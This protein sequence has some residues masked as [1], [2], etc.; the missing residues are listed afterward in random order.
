MATTKE[1]AFLA[2]LDFKR[3]EAAIVILDIIIQ[4]QHDWDINCTT[5][6]ITPFVSPVLDRL[7][8]YHTQQDLDFVTLLAHNHNLNLLATGEQGWTLLH[9]TSR[10]GN[11]SLLSFIL[12]NGGRDLIDTKVNGL[13][14]LFTALVSGSLLAARFL[15]ERGGADP[16][17]KVAMEMGTDGQQTM[18]S[19]FEWTV[20]QEAEG[21]PTQMARVLRSLGGQL[22]QPVS[23]FG[24]FR[25]SEGGIFVMDRMHSTF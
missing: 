6:A 3:F 7:S 2:A 19:S 17:G 9:L 10:D 23:R 21:K 5:D 20:L 11:V 4:H 24:Q 1:A 14:P 15:I 8:R 18:I 16:N 25:V 13:T 12:D 22:H